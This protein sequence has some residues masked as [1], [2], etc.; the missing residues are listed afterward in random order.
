VK[1]EGPVVFSLTSR[2]WSGFADSSL[3]PFSANPLPDVGVISK[4]LP[5]LALGENR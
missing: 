3:E 5:I 4:P 2:N 1:N